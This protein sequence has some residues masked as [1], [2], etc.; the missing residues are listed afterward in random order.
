MKV[1]TFNNCNISVQTNFRI[2]EKG[3]EKIIEE[4][5]VDYKG[6]VS[7]LQS[8]ILKR[9]KYEKADIKYIGT[10]NNAITVDAEI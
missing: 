6:H 1:K 4:F 2:W 3:T 7:E 5:T 9:I 8:A 10:Y